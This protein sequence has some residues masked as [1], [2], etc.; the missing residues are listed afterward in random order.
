MNLIDKMLVFDPS[1]RI[2]AGRP[3]QEL[4]PKLDPSLKAPP[5][6]KFDAEKG[7]TVLST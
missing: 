3:A 7:I 6:S 5:V 4:E 1:N 2:T